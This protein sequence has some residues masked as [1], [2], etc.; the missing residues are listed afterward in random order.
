VRSLS[1]CEFGK[2][3]Q[4]TS[5]PRKYV[6]MARDVVQMVVD[7]SLLMGFPRP[8]FNFGSIG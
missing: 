3:P 4:V 2:F 8:W 7:L 5:I 6:L 1:A